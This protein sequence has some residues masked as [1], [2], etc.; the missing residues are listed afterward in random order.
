[1]SNTPSRIA[2]LV[3]TFDRYINVKSNKWILG[4]NKILAEK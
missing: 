3:E 1:M 2:E 4:S